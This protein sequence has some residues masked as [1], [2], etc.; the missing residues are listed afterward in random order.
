MLL[1]YYWYIIGILLVYYWY[2]I[3]VGIPSVEGLLSAFRSLSFIP[4]SVSL[5]Y[6][7]AY[8]VRGI[9]RYKNGDYHQFLQSLNNARNLN[10]VLGPAEVCVG[11]DKVC[12]GFDKVCIG[13]GKRV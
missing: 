8:V 13:P 5:S 2:I 11:S 4:V 1:V 6:T 3:G 12:V 9:G 10:T 7:L